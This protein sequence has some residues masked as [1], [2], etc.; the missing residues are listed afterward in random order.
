[1]FYTATFKLCTIAKIGQSGYLEK[2]FFLKKTQSLQL[3]LGILL[4]LLVNFTWNL[5]LS[6]FNKL[7]KIGAKYNT[8]L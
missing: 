6:S 5:Q 1:M 7:S 2:L 4:F 8:Y 3:L